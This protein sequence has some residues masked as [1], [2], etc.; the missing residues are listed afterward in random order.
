LVLRNTQ[1]SFEVVHTVE[2]DKLT[3]FVVLSDK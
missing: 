1:F 2:H 3:A